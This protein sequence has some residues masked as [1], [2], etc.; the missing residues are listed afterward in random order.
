MQLLR[1]RGQRCRRL[2]RRADRLESSAPW[3]ARHG[4]RPIISGHAQVARWREHRAASMP[5]ELEPRRAGLWAPAHAHAF[6]H[7]VAPP[8]SRIPPA[9]H[10]LVVCRKERARVAAHAGRQRHKRPAS[11]DAANEWG[12]DEGP[13]CCVRQPPTRPGV[14]RLPR[15]AGAGS[16]LSAPSVYSLRPNSLDARR[17]R[18]LASRVRFACR[19]VVQLTA[20]QQYGSKVGLLRPKSTV[21]QR[22]IDRDRSSA[23]AI[24]VLASARIRFSASESGFHP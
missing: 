1:C 7:A 18:L 19:T 22:A 17:G 13:G 6:P 21:R 11:V 24:M 23:R 10:R 14:V 12:H 5:G 16:A 8:G 3:R 20:A 4:R 15:G 2:H 9:T